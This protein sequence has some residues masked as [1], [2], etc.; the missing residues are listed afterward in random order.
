MQN[1]ASKPEQ[2]IHHLTLFLAL[3]IPVHRIAIAAPDKKV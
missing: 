3:T 1:L 2:H